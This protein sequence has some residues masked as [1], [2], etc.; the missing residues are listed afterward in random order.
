MMRRRS[1]APM[2]PVTLQFIVAMFAHA[3][4]EQMARRVE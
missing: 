3:I 4:N 1:R 2:L